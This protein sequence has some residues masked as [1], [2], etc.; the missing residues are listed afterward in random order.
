[1]QEDQQEAITVD[2]VKTN[3][4]KVQALLARTSESR[5]KIKSAGAI[6]GSAMVGF[7]VTQDQPRLVFLVLALTAAVFGYDAAL[8]VREEQL[9]KLNR[10]IERML[11]A[12]ARG[13]HAALLREGA[14]ITTSVPKSTDGRWMRVFG[15]SRW[16]FWLPY[17]V[18]T[19][20]VGAVGVAAERHELV[21]R[22]A[23]PAPAGTP[24]ARMH[25]RA[26]GART[27][28][29]DGYS[30]AGAGTQPAGHVP[31]GASVDAAGEITALSD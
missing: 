1:M 14:R 26:P 30:G 28:P 27:D 21:R 22:E 13:D 9:L 7:G 29:A 25:P 11:T 16:L 20:I 8:K 31:L 6:A 24:A 4:E 2:L 10:T 15:F 12:A 5:W 18:V 19:I 3:W 17:L 23:P